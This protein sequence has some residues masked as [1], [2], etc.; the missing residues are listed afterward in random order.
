MLRKLV[1]M[2]RICLLFLFSGLFFSPSA[3]AQDFSFNELIKL[4]TTSLTEFETEVMAKGYDLADVSKENDQVVAF[5]KGTN[6]ISY[7]LI[8]N[9]HAEGWDTVIT[10]K[11]YSND[12]YNAVKK[13][14]TDD[15]IHPDIIHFFNDGMYITH[16][17][18]DGRMCVHFRTK[19]NL[20]TRYEVKV[21][22]DNTDRYNQYST[23][24]GDIRW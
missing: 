19:Q 21:I 16:V 4:R 20:E 18:V 8:R 6:R 9:P 12:E 2:S 10:Y 15:P 7:S 17:Y 24:K 23:L 1:S 3:H 11:T 13:Q 14:K 5:K 22:P